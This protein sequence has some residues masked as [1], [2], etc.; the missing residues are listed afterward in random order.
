[1]Q[2][3]EHELKILPSL[4]FVLLDLAQY[5][6]IQE[7][8]AEASDYDDAANYHKHRAAE[9]RAEAKRIVQSWDNM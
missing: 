8:M 9:L 2:F 5:H 4:P 1:M 6:S 3:T 7:T